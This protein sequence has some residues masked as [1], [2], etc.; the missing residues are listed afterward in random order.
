MPAVRQT[1]LKQLDVEVYPDTKLTSFKYYNNDGKT[2]DYEKSVYF[3][4]LFSAKRSD[5]RL[6][7]MPIRQRHLQT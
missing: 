3:S 6:S 7:S 5:G 2:Y 1:P 4:Q